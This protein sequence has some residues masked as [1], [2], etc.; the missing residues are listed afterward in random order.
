MMACTGLGSRLLDW[1]AG[2]LVARFACCMRN[3]ANQH[4]HTTRSYEN[5]TTTHNNT[6][7]QQHHQ[8][9]NLLLQPLQGLPRPLLKVCD[10]GY[11]KQDDRASVISK[12]GTVRTP[13]G[14]RLTAPRTGLAGRAGLAGAAGSVARASATRSTQTAS[15]PWPNN[16]NTRH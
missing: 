1:A 2:S 8:L 4:M 9:D 3:S 13:F 11:S 15:R 6:Q 5:T 12:V 10:F 16:M 7:L 14:L